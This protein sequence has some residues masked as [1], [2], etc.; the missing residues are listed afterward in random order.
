MRKIDIAGAIETAAEEATG[1]S[2]T[3][4]GQIADQFEL[5]E[6]ARVRGLTLRAIAIAA[7]VK[8]D[9]FTNTF[10]AVAR[11]R[12]G[13]TR[14]GK[15]RQ[16]GRLHVSPAAAE[17]ELKTPA[18]AAAVQEPPT[19]VAGPD[20]LIGISGPEAEAEDTKQGGQTKAGLRMW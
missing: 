18:L 11:K 15:P 3:L 8:P 16:R 7:G 10:R 13:L 1:A 17:A 5:I 19:D 20:W 14:T 4:T 6:A 2:Q 9:V 12:Q